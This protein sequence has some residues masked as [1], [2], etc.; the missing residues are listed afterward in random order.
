MAERTCRCCGKAYDYPERGGSATRNFCSPCAELP[1]P[2]RHVVQVLQSDLRRMTRRLE[3]LE[4]RL[5]EK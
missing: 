5:P 3:A 4:Q 2:T 1:E